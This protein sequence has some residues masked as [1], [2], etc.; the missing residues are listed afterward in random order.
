MAATPRPR[1][2][3]TP[4]RWRRRRLL[5]TMLFAK[6][7]FGAFGLLWSTVAGWM[8]GCECSVFIAD[9]FCRLHRRQACEMLKVFAGAFADMRV[10][11]AAHG[12]PA[13]QASRAVEAC[14]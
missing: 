2:A 10:C 8:R 1:L 9:S 14:G 7:R 6:V 3:A 11:W 5:V 13:I 12:A 4:M